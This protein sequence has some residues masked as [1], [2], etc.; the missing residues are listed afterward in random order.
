MFIPVREAYL[1]LTPEEFEKYSL[2]MLLEQTKGLENL[3]IEHDRVIEAY[4]GNYQIDGYIEFTVMGIKYET[5][6][7]C[8]HYKS[9]ITRE[10][11]Q[12]LYEKIQSTG[13]HKGILI[14]T[15]NFQSGAIQ[16]ASI[17]GIALIQ[18]TEADMHY[19]T[20]GRL[21]VV[22]QYGLP[23]RNYGKKYVAVFLNQ[24]D[25]GG[26]TCSHLSKTRRTLKDFIVDNLIASEL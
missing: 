4:D 18:L 7:E 22:V 17:H 24:G 2:E 14:S 13:A 20:R 8:K 21:N 5:L 16:Y 19:E 12:I 23:P 15:S 11:V 9:S 1:E 10:K 3:K 6:V 25:S 26:I